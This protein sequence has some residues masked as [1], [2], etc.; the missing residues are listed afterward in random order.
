RGHGPHRLHDVH[1]AEDPGRGLQ[2]EEPRP[3]R[4]RD[5]GH[6]ARH[7]RGVGGFRPIRTRNPEH[8]MDLDEAILTAEDSM[9]KAVEYLRNE[10]RGVRTGRASTGLVEFIKVDYYGSMTDLRSVAL[11]SVPEATQLLIKP[12]DAST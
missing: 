12:F 5:G 1:G 8:R 2:H 6:A 10:L 4:R 7:P 11:V 9:E 3:H